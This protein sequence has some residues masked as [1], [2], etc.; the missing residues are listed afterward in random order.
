M[1]RENPANGCTDET[2]DKK[3]RRQEAVELHGERAS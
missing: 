3:T 2:E 1:M